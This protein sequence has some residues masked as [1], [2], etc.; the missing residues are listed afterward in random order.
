MTIEEANQIIFKLK[1]GF[2]Y[3]DDDDWDSK[4]TE[5]KY[6]PQK[7]KFMII[8]MDTAV[9][10]RWPDEE[11]DEKVIWRMLIN[12]YTY[13]EFINEMIYDRTHAVIHEN[14]SRDKNL[15]NPV[16]KDD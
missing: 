11:Y 9:G 13:E 12:N 14:Q 2:I 6:I 5:I 15:Q 8:Q 1:N 10:Y 3:S 4:I 7:K 16:D